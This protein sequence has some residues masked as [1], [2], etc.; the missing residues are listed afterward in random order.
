MAG[1]KR[2]GMYLSRRSFIA[3]G[4][5]YAT[6][7]NVSQSSAAT[8][9]IRPARAGKTKLVNVI[10]SLANPYNNWWSKGG[11]QCAAHYDLPY[12]VVQTEG[13]F[14]RKG[15]GQIQ[16]II[17]QEHGNVVFNI[18]APSEQKDLHA[19]VELCTHK[20]V[21]FVTQNSMPPVSARPWAF[22]S[23]TPYYVAHI[24]FDH[25]LAG[26]RTGRQLM[27]AVGDQGG[28]LVMSGPPDNAFAARRLSG[29]MSAFSTAPRCYTLCPPADAEWEASASYDIARS[30]IAQCGVDRVAGVWAANDDMALGA[31]DALQVY[32][33][34]VPVTGI[35]GIKQAVDAVQNG[36]MTAT[37]AW[38]SFWQGGIGLSLAISAKTGLLNPLAEPR[39]HRAFYGPFGLVTADNVLDFIAYRDAK[40]PFEDWRD[41]WGRSTGPMPDV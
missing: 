19:L 22:G 16:D 21:Y 36:K 13:D 6:M 26:Y 38:D 27:S 9:P 37:I 1:D 12:A 14:H 17:D 10:T 30:L 25:Q 41:F 20:H 29:L 40:G 11:Q 33:R 35:D 31:I 24:D 23:T 2:R 15:L 32:D 28:I 4:V 34:S 5:S 3:C 39:S 7:A 8:G 18:D